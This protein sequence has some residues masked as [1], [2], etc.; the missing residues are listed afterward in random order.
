MSRWTVSVA[1]FLCISVTAVQAQDYLTEANASS[2]INGE[3]VGISRDNTDVAALFARFAVP[4][5][6]C[7]ASCITPTSVAQGVTALDKTPAMALLLNVVAPNKGQ[8]AD[9]REQRFHGNGPSTNDAGM[10]I[11]HFL[12]QSNPVEEFRYYPSGMRSWSVLGSST[13]VA[14]S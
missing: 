6:S 5:D 14:R 12:T 2:I 13:E 10:L 1:A 4:E 3:R 7:A 9:A 11:N 8:M